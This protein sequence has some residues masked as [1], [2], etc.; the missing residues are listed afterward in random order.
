MNSITKRQ[1]NDLNR[2]FY[3]ER[4]TEFD[5]TRQH[6]WPGWQNVIERLK[7]SVRGTRAR[8]LDIACGNGRFAQF[9]Q[10][11]HPVGAIEYT[12][13]DQS[14]ALLK[15]AEKECR[16]SDADRLDWLLFDATSD[17]LEETPLP[18]QNHLVVAFG[19]LHHIPSLE[20]R[21]RLIA[22]LSEL[23]DLNGILVFT[24]WRFNHSKRF[25]DKIIPW[26]DYNRQADDKIDTDELESGDYLMSFG[27]M[28]STPRY[29]HAATELETEALLESLALEQVDRF[30]ADG[31]SNDLNE[32]FVFQKSVGKP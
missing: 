18:D 20:S 25:Q 5:G 2:R 10:K 29:C 3:E 15:I 28:G 32:Y 4:A 12:G 6:E 13:V 27:D 7:P 16:E 17:A 26:Q 1:L 23:V 11:D 8:V 19:L 14:P 22:H 24:L 30:T 9:L 31:K 21:K